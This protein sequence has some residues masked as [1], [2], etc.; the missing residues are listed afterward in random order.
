MITYHTNNLDYDDLI[1]EIIKETESSGADQFSLHDDG[2]HIPTIGIGFNVTQDFVRDAVLDHFSVQANEGSYDLSGVI[3]NGG[4]AVNY[5]D[6]VEDIIDAFNYQAG[7]GVPN[8]G[9]LTSFA[10]L[11]SA[12]DDLMAAW[13][14]D[15]TVTLPVNPRSTFSFLTPQEVVDTFDTITPVFDQLIADFNTHDNIGGITANSREKAALFSL[16]YNSPTNPSTHPT[17]PLLPV[18]LGEKLGDALRVGDRAEAWFE[19]RY[20]S[21]LTG[22][23][24]VAKRRILESHVFGLYDELQPDANFRVSI[25]ADALSVFRMLNKHESKILAYETTHGA[26][27]AQ[28]D[29]NLNGVTPPATG[30]NGINA[31]YSLGNLGEIQD[32]VQSFESARRTLVERYADLDVIA[33]SLRDLLGQTA[34][35]G[36]L[37]RL[38]TDNTITDGLLTHLTIDDNLAANLTDA[39][40][41][42][43][44][45]AAEDQPNGEVAA[46]TVDRSS[47]TAS[48]DLIFGSIEETLPGGGTA[49]VGIG[50]NVDNTLNGGGG[51]DVFIGGGGADVI[52]GGADE[53][54]VFYVQ[55]DAGVTV[56]LNSATAQSG[57]YAQGDVLSNIENVIGSQFDDV[58]TGDSGNNVLIGLNGADM[59]LGGDGDDVLVGGFA[60]EDPTDPNGPSADGAKDTLDGGAG[61]DTLISQAGEDEILNF[62]QGIDTAFTGG[63]E[64]FLKIAPFDPSLPGPPVNSFILGG[65]GFDAVDYSNFGSGIA[66]T[67]AALTTPDPNLGAIGFEINASGGTLALYSV[68]GLTGSAGD[69]LIDFTIAGDDGSIGYAID[70]GDGADTIIGGAGDD[71]ILGSI[72]LDTL[73]GGAG[74]DTFVISSADIDATTAVQ[75]DIG[76][77]HFD[78]VYVITDSDADDRLVL[79][80]LT[81]LGGSPVIVTALSGGIQMPTIFGNFGLPKLL[82]SGALRSDSYS[83]HD[84]FYGEQYFY[85]AQFEVAYIRINNK[86]IIIQDFQIGDFGLDFGDLNPQFAVTLVPPDVARAADGGPQL[87]GSQT[88]ALGQFGGGLVFQGGPDGR[89]VAG[90]GFFAGGIVDT[91]PQN[92]TG[93]ASVVST[94]NAGSGVDIEGSFN[95]DDALSTPLTGTDFADII[96]GHEG[97]DFIS[98]L[99]GND[100]ISGGE[101]D[102]T[103]DAGAGDDIVNADNGVN[104]ADGGTGFDIIQFDGAIDDY[105]IVNRKASDDLNIQTTEYQ[106][107]VVAV[108][109]LRTATDD[110]TAADV[111]VIQNFE[112]LHFLGGAQTEIRQTQDAFTFI[113]RGNID[114]WLA[115]GAQ[116]VSLTQQSLIDHFD[117]RIINNPGALLPDVVAVYLP[118]NGSVIKTGADSWDFQFDNAATSEAFVTV[119]AQDTNGA[120]VENVLRIIQPDTPPVTVADQ[121]DF[122]FGG[123]LTIFESALLQNDSDPEGGDLELISASNPSFGSLSFDNGAVTL[124]TPTDFSGQF[125]FTYTVEDESGAQ[126]QGQATVNVTPP[127]LPPV[128]TGTDGFDFFQGTTGSDHFRGGAGNDLI[129]GLVGLDALFGDSGDDFI[130]GD[131]GDPFAGA[132]GDD[133]LDGGAGNDIIAGRGG[134]DRVLFGAGYGTDIIA[135]QE[136]IET[137]QFVGGITASDITV[138][139]ISIEHHDFGLEFDQDEGFREFYVDDENTQG[140]LE[141]ALSQFATSLTSRTDFASRLITDSGISVG[142]HDFSADFADL[143]SLGE[144]LVFS[145]NGTNDK[146][147]IPLTFSFS[148]GTPFSL[149]NVVFG[150]GAE[151]VVDHNFDITTPLGQLLSQSTDGDDRVVGLVSAPVLN[152]GLGDDTL[153]GRDEANGYQFD[154][155]DGADVVEDLG[156]SNAVTD[157]IGFGA[158]ITA[159]DLEFSLSGIYLDD[160]TISITGTSDSITIRNQFTFVDSLNSSDPTTPIR[161]LRIE[162]IRFSDGSDINWNDVNGLLDYQAID[163]FIAAIPAAQ[164]DDTGNNI[165]QN[166]EHLP[167]SELDG[168]LGD[169]LLIGGQDGE[170][171]YFEADYGNDIILEG[172]SSSVSDGDPTLEVDTVRFGANVDPADVIFT[173]GGIRGDDLVISVPKAGGG[174]STLNI[175]SQFFY[176][177]PAEIRFPSTPDGSTPY[178]IEQFVFDFD[179]STLTWDQVETR[180]FDLLDSN[181]WLTG[182]PQND[183]LTGTPWEDLA[184]GLDG[185]DVIKTTFGADTIEGGAGDDFLQGGDGD[186]TYIYKS[187][188]GNDIIQETVSFDLSGGEGEGA[189]PEHIDR[190]VFDDLLSGDLDFRISALDAD[191]L[192]IRDNATGHEIIV[193]SQ[194]KTIEPVGVGEIE[195]ADGVIWDRTQINAA[196][197]FIRDANQTINGTSGDDTITG[198]TGHDSLKGF[199]GSD[200]YVLVANHGDDWIKDNA[201]AIDIDVIQFDPSIL[202]GHLEVVRTSGNFGDLLIINNVTGDVVEVDRHFALSGNE[203]IEQ[204]AFGDATVWDRAFLVANAETRGT[205]AAE[206]MYGTT[207]D[208]KFRGGL[209]DDTILGKQGSD[210]YR[211]AAG[212]GNDK[213]DEFGLAG[214]TDRIVFDAGVN[215]GDIR[216]EKNTA[217][218]NDLFLINDITGDVIE[219]DQHFFAATHGIE[220]ITF[221]DGTI[222]NAAHIIANVTM[223]GT[224]AGEL[225]T[226]NSDA[227]RIRGGLGND[228]MPG[229]EGSDDYL[230]ASGDGNDKI[231]EFGLAGDTD[232]IVFDAGVNPGDIRLEKNTSVLNDLF[233][234]NEVTGDIIEVDQ[235]FLSAAHGVEEIVFS[236]AIVWN[237][238]FIVANV[239][240]VGTSLAD[241]LSGNTDDERIRGGLGNDTLLGRAGSDDYLFGASD[242]ADYLDEFGVSTDTDRI[243]FDAGIL[244]TDL[245]L[246]RGL[247]NTDDVIITNVNTGATIEIDQQRNS[248]TLG[249]EEIHFDN[250]TIWDRTDIET[251]SN[252]TPPLAIDLDGDGVELISARDSNVYF[253]FDGDGIRER[254][255]WVAGDDGLLVLDRNGDGRIAG[256]SEIS[257]LADL[258]GART[259]LEGLGGFDSNGDGALS[260]ADDRFNEFF[261]WQDRNSNG[262]SDAGE[263]TRLGDLGI[264]S[265]DPVGGAPVNAAP[266]NLTD[267][268]ILGG[269]VVTWSDGRETDLADV[270]LRYVDRARN[271]ND[272]EF[273]AMRDEVTD[274]NDAREDGRVNEEEPTRLEYRSALDAMRD[275]IEQQKEEQAANG[276]ES[277]SEAESSDEV[278]MTKKAPPLVKEVHQESIET[279]PVETPVEPQ[280]EKLNDAPVERPFQPLIEEENDQ[281][282]ET[283]PAEKPAEPLVEKVTEEPTD[284]S[285]IEPPVK[286]PFDVEIPLPYEIVSADHIDFG[287]IDA[288]GDGLVAETPPLE[289]SGQG[290][291]AGEGYFELPPEEPFFGSLNANDNGVLEIT[292]HK[293]FAPIG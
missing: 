148:T 24:G 43:V 92:P 245:L 213:I 159:A 8:D 232:R 268:T 104:T 264:V 226:G 199:A 283:S 239:T 215:P 162:E 165:I 260:A 243:I 287:N 221:D 58:I 208:E 164:V 143:A 75:N 224:I 125:T 249:I 108:Y 13:A 93:G 120:F 171:Y 26:Q 160:L 32:F 265:I 154:L 53:D 22:E 86:E 169:D 267:N 111:T 183:D 241:S 16:T 98:A 209:G 50:A 110:P 158:G 166:F 82:D 257:F 42:N 292:E 68:E 20:N 142:Q 78:R 274:A 228:T 114:P 2:R 271:P 236:D 34:Y 182:T 262:R 44:Y 11:Q 121:V 235:H 168:G 150:D 203:G 51:D 192:I 99:D 207:D 89:F 129:V 258:A 246:S 234:I 255:G 269:A 288:L 119:V 47:A 112:E 205:A 155:G 14:A 201:N 157:Y 284:T 56:D 90:E 33:P 77:R 27:Y 253:D 161:T 231:D 4:T 273:E 85:D 37:T 84:G 122:L 179:G 29:L 21:N 152:G 9:N 73:T 247:I 263:L 49:I 145:I 70:G 65:D 193:E 6:A 204:I 250:G 211:I 55:S 252:T 210:D 46:H 60:A 81:L 151:W 41:R 31:R 19:I 178:R 225:L 140:Q 177:L 67:L 97:D 96:N 109:D 206:T 101:G 95:D 136:G 187:G 218:L 25:E 259:D 173:R 149:T 102:D 174:F 144:A 261:V 79:D 80:G 223:V 28:A 10:E 242:G 212:D 138:D 15:Q 52:D 214:D 277:N 91:T 219:V 163:S 66:I 61:A 202:P 76:R 48:H 167:L 237:A 128:V 12:L 216:L 276:A 181:T 217:M 64:D 280:A 229:K 106:D 170:N 124:V 275:L 281:P 71:V 278:V 291:G 293:E 139:L 7:Q 244:P 137:L 54:S 39:A 282:I 285:P 113:R 197:I 134:I 270:A 63:S 132:S 74:A 266:V 272:I 3:T 172:S 72:G 115:R 188:D 194:F 135:G 185:D 251:L 156:N 116:S 18:L 36:H 69:D 198:G 5:R 40:I 195:F 23:D 248:T 240:L 238:A 59:L 35:T 100:V 117:Y 153:I 103:I 180:A 88:G 233:L 130:I 62:E 222:W 146:I 190:L 30:S 17:R 184:F 127:V 230:I 186:D 256:V 279:A 175:V 254:G 191:D 147:I 176:R 123:T 220:E 133:I 107:D 1:F 290:E 286:L 200:T 118:Q 131:G 289:I 126:A 57:G 105:L 94:A 83:R 38:T 45:V 141:F 189:A 227:E 196:S 87:P